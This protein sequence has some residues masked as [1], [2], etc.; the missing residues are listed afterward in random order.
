VSC[1]RTCLRCTL[2]PG[3]SR[4][5]RL[6]D[7]SGIMI[8]TLTRDWHLLF[9]DDLNYKVIGIRSGRMVARLGIA[10]VS[11]DLGSIDEMISKPPRCRQRTFAS[12]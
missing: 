5:Y 10:D 6:V 1:T 12:D 8:D 4:Q 2:D 11:S 9:L 3:L 7:F